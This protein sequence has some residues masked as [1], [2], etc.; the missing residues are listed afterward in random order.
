MVKKMAENN[1]LCPVK[2]EGLK[3]IYYVLEE[4]SAYL[5]NP[6]HP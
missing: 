1:A 4:N 6:I 2:I 5:R 3:H